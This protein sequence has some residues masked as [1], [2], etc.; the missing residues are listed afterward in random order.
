MLVI[1]HLPED[2]PF[3]SSAVYAFKEQVRFYY[4]E[5]RCHKDRLEDPDLERRGI[6]QKK[7]VWSAHE[8][9]G[10]MEQ[11]KSN[12]RSSSDKNQNQRWRE[13]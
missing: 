6:L 2:L 13:I 8:S 12:R 4:S 11:Q 7:L 5:S 3:S 1:D 10:K 9:T